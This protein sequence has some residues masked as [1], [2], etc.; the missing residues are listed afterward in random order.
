MAANLHLIHFIL[1][2]SSVTFDFFS[3]ENISL[4]LINRQILKNS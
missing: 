2:T 1:Q 4:R 3:I